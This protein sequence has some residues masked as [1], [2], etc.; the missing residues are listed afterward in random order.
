M[1]GTKRYMLSIAAVL[2]LVAACGGGTGGNDRD[3]SLA[4]AGSGG[5]FYAYGGALST[6]MSKAIDDFSLTAQTTGGSEENMK[7]LGTGDVQ[8][9]EG[10]APAVE[11]AYKGE[12]AFKDSAQDIRLVS[13]MYPDIV[14][15]T[16]M[17]DSSIS[18]Y[19]DLKGQSVSVGEPGSGVQLTLDVIT[20]ATGLS[21]DDF[22]KMSRLGY[23]EQVAAMR[24]GQIDVASFMGP[25]GM[26]ALQDL[27]SSKNISILPFSKPNME[28]ITKAAPY[29]TSGEL[30]ANTYKNQPEAVSPIP[31][32]WN[33]L[34]VPAD[35]DDDLVKQITLAIFDNTDSLAE[36]VP[37]AEDTTPENTVDNAIIPLHPGAAAAMKELNVDVPDDLV[38][39]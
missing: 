32:Q 37:A 33:Y 23:D 4:T 8:I 21:Y 13:V 9:A 27:S 25:A 16:S 24:N 3:W 36:S 38:N 31:S 11:Q 18:T 30:P 15:L 22:G 6:Q 10:Q 39:D 35:A 29:I 20:K 12:G 26:S 2:L 5:T 14:Q 17:E 19:E 7:L 34:V 28:K 1:H